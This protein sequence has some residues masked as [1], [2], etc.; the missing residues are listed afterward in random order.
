MIGLGAAQCI[1]EIMQKQAVCLLTRWSQRRSQCIVW[2]LH[3]T[4]DTEDVMNYCSC[5]CNCS[6]NELSSQE[7]RHHG[8]DAADMTNAVQRPHALA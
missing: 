5:V 4:N 3:F 1:V 8:F 2:L 6:I 7:L